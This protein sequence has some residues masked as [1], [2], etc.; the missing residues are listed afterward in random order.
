MT[1][2]KNLKIRTKLLIGYAVVLLALLIVALLGSIDLLNTDRVYTA[3]IHGPVERLYTIESISTALM[4]TRRLVALASLHGGEYDALGTLNELE[5]EITSNQRYLTQLLN[6]YRDN[7]RHDPNADPQ[8]AAGLIAQ[9]DEIE[10]LFN[11]YVRDIMTPILGHARAG[12]RE[13]AVEMIVAGQS[14]FAEINDIYASLSETAINTMHATS[15]GITVSTNQTL[16]IL[17][18]ISVIAVTLSIVF[19]MYISSSIANP[20]REVANALE[21]VARGRLNTNIRINSTDETGMLANST[22]QVVKTIQVLMDDMDKMGEDQHHGILD[23]FIDTSKFEGSFVTVAEKI[24][25]MIQ[26]EIEAMKEVIDVFSKIADGEFDTTIRQFPGQLAYVN[27]AVDQ[28]RGNIKKVSASIDSVI[29]AASIQGDMAFKVDTAGFN[30]G[31]LEIMN[32]L[33]SVCKAVDEPITEVRGIMEKLSVG[34]FSAKVTG[35]YPGDFKAI[36]DAV[37]STID[38]LN[39][40]ISEMSKILSDV[41]GGHL[42]RSIT[43]EYV[44]SFS[45]I[46]SSINNITGTLH[47]TMSEINASTEQVLSGAK[48]ISQSAMDLANGAQSQASSVEEL[49]ASV[50]LINQQTRSNAENAE[51]ASG[52]SSQSTTNA[53]EGNDAMK[54]M[55]EAMLAIRES[56]SSISRI[57][58]T[59]QDIAFQTN[60]LSLNAAVEAARAGEH[61]KGF[62]VV[63]EEVR[64]LAARSQEAASETTELIQTSIDR[65]ETGSSIAQSTAT[66]LDTI[67]SSANDIMSIINTISAASR[68]QADA[69]DQISIG[70]QQISNVV[71]SNS[72]VSEETAAAAE[73][74]NSQ[75]EILQ[76]LVSYFKL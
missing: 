2:I 51:N 72:A 23:S 50:D 74:L 40:Y 29:D 57:I 76:Q 26:D 73:E 52:L 69:I 55:L 27:D 5:S 17:I 15:D 63:A 49:N 11:I 71:Q 10:R 58:K 12:N 14:M 30:A 46:K 60:L 22:R 18:V 67:V 59:I 70:L 54:Q 41:A 39:G 66:S 48:Q 28:M 62:G 31:W 61:G 19:A 33:N 32:G 64:S 7:F 53:Q 13:A 36:G 47:K 65:V 68:E 6:A 1:F 45:E 21:D 16:T 24:N 75:S 4:D 43:R 37:N 44:G 34:D 38:A 3:M 9:A 56:S 25:T 42:N 20:V 35:R 8:A